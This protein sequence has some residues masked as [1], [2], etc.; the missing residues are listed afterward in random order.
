MRALENSLPVDRRAPS[1]SPPGSRRHTRD[2]LPG[3]VGGAVGAMAAVG[4]GVGAPQQPPG[5]AAWV[6]GGP[7]LLL[8]ADVPD[9]GGG[10]DVLDDEEWDAGP[11]GPTR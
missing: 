11:A 4:S 10:G 7:P 2:R 3:S 9:G 6:P 1:P 8:P 5:G